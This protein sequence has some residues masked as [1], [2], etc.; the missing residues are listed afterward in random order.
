MILVLVNA[1]LETW[2]TFLDPPRRFAAVSLHQASDIA[3]A[4]AFRNDPRLGDDPR[5]Q[6]I[7]STSPFDKSPSYFSD[8]ATAVESGYQAYSG[9][10]ALLAA[11]M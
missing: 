8:N 10:P 1:Q 9:S 3:N 6:L 4:L 2:A 11:G 7:N 5:G